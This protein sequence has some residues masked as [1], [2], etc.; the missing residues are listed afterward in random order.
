MFNYSSDNLISKEIRI[1]IGKR[2]HAERIRAKISL[3]KLAEL[4]GYSKPTVQRW[5]KGWKNG[6]GENIIPTLDQIIELCAI[7]KCSPGY[8]L[9]EYHDRTKQAFDAAL[10]LGLTEEAVNRLQTL[11]TSQVDRLHPSDIDAFMCFLNYLICH[12]DYLYNLL[13]DRLR[14][15]NLDKVTTNFIPGIDIAKKAFDDPNIQR[16]LLQF[17]S[18]STD[19]LAREI[20]ANGFDTANLAL[21][22]A[23]KSYYEKHPNLTEKYTSSFL[24]KSALQYINKVF[25]MSQKQSDFLISETFLDIVKSFCDNSYE[26]YNKYNKFVE[27]QFQKKLKIDPDLLNHLILEDW[28]K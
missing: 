10:E 14:M 5:E 8:L 2:L 25:P 11:H 3:D 4:T 9:C 6:T 22:I 26:E 24:A 13:R 15:A 23:L 12:S 7:Y 1:E 27:Q 28:S 16:L 19:Y 17:R 20:D 18:S 21:L